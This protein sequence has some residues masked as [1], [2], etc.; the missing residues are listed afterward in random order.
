M[1]SFGE[2]S[3]PSLVWRRNLGLVHVIDKSERLALFVQ[4]L[5]ELLDGLGMGSAGDFSEALRLF[6]RKHGSRLKARH[7]VAPAGLGIFR[8]APASFLRARRPEEGRVFGASLRERAA[9][10]MAVST[11]DAFASGSTM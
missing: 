11:A 10:R 7:A 9:R 6:L 5:I 2:T 1:N 3:S 8:H 4:Q